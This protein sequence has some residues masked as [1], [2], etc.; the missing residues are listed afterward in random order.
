[1]T[2]TALCVTVAHIG[3]EV[4]ARLVP[5]PPVSRSGTSGHRSIQSLA[6]GYTIPDGTPVFRFDLHPDPFRFIVRGPM[7]DETLPPGTMRLLFGQVVPYDDRPW[8]QLGPLTVVSLDVKVAL[9]EAYGVPVERW[10]N[11][12]E[13]IEDGTCIHT[14]H[15]MA[16]GK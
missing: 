5:V 3:G 9:A 1:M 16:A 4:S 10:V 2:D 12:P 14:S 11:C 8:D 13:F 15:M 7:L 6:E